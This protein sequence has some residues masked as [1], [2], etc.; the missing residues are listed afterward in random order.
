MHRRFHAQLA[1][2]AALPLLAGGC[3]MMPHS[4]MVVFGT[5]TV[6]GVR[7]G[8]AATQVPSIDIGYSRQEA[9][10]MPVVANATLATDRTKAVPCDLSA[11]VKLVAGQV[12]PQDG[13]VLAPHPCLLVAT[14]DREGAR[15][16]YS[17]LASFGANF[18]GSSKTTEATA[19][20][21]LAQYFATGM[22]AQLLA[23]NGG[24]AVVAAGPAAQ[25]AAAKPA[26]T[27]EGESGKARLDAA[28]QGCTQATVTTA[29]INA[30]LH[31]LVRVAD[32]TEQARRLALA[33]SAVNATV[34][35]DNNATWLNVARALNTNFCTDA[36][37][38]AVTDKI[39]QLIG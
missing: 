10:L 37:R 19:Q 2:L 34:G 35:A 15:D 20:G 14:N 16:S 22:A 32:A 13:P 36:D 12:D 24:A 28:V 9:V 8:T 39:E 1:A 11:N 27:L 25:Q 23:L 38:S 33:A 31:T 30:R 3:A 4:N 26:L 5:N 21:G 18:G 17:V 7:V 6:L 29:Q